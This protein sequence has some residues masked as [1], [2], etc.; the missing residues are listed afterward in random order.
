[1]RSVKS[2]VKGCKTAGTVL[3]VIVL[4]A[5]GLRAALPAE[6][7]QPRIDQEI[8]KQEKTGAMGDRPVEHLRLN[9]FEGLSRA[10]NTLN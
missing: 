3:I 2:S 9:H 5:F 4:Q 8:T 6:P 7:V 10:S 1:M